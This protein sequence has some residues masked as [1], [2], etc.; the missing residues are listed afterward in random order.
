MDTS[1][2][3]AI[4]AFASSTVGGYFAYRSSIQAN[5]V[6]SRKVDQTAYDRAIEFYQKQ[7]DDANKQIER[8]TSQM[9]KL[10]LQ[11]DRVTI[12]LGAEQDISAS[13]RKQVLVLQ[14]QLGILGETIADLR[15][16]INRRPSKGV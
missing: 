11:L 15:S 8:I 14:S 9:D 10:N 1:L 13:L 3:I 7:L 12:Q 2:V 5:R 4:L 6:E 16:K